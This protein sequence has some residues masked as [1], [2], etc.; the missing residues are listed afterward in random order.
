MLCIL[1]S[2]HVCPKL[3]AL[4]VLLL[5]VVDKDA[6]AKRKDFRNLPRH[7]IDLELVVVITSSSIR[8]CKFSL[9]EN[10]KLLLE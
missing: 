2:R 10:S 1:V 9:S 5:K 3:A 7:H 8:G 6:L 4:S